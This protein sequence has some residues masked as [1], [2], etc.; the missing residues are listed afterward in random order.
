MKNRRIIVASFLICACL[1]MGIGYAAFS[2]VMDINGTAEIQKD[3]VYDGNVIFTDAVA[4]PR[5]DGEATMNTAN[6]NPNNPDKAAFTVK[7]LVTQG[8]KATFQFTI[9]NTNTEAFKISL[10]ETTLVNQDAQNYFIVEDDLGEEGKTIEANGGTIVV[11]LVVTLNETPASDV[12]S[13]SANFLTEL[14][15][16]PVAQQATE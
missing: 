15:V 5:L 6:I 3:N 9:K 2:D 1:V 14:Q 11:T 12:T 10:K 4:V 7:D 8:E 16:E 13:I